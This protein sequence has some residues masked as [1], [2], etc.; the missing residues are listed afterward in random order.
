MSPGEVVRF[1]ALPWEAYDAFG[2]LITPHMPDVVRWPRQ[3]FAAGWPTFTPDGRH[4]IGE[5]SRAPGLVM[6]AGC[7]AHGIAGAPA[8]GRLVAESLE[9]RRTP[10]LESLSPDRFL[11]GFTWDDAIAAA[12]R[13][14]ETY[15]TLAAQAV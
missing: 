10:Y 13:Q 11:R 2:D 3:A 7:N 12:R 9:P 6:A 8:L 1:P 15:N 14:S 4:V 5:S